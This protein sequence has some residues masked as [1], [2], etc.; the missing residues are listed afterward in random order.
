MGRKRTPAP[1][2]RSAQ[3]TD[4]AG[5]ARRLAPD[6]VVI[7]GLTVLVDVIAIAAG[8]AV[9]LPSADGRAENAAEDRS[10]D[11]ATYRADARKHRTGNCTANRA[12][13]SAGRDTAALAVVI[14]AVVV[15]V[16]IMAIVIAVAVISVVVPLRAITVAVIGIRG[17]ARRGDAAGGD[18]HKS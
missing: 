5:A 15:A 11:R 2:I 7:A 1:S 9:I 10:G 12:N 18:G 13:R 17:A 4:A 16:A 14:V 6:V 3:S 8:I